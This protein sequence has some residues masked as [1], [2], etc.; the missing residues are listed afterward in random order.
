MHAQYN[1]RSIIMPRLLQVTNQ[2]P[3]T[4]DDPHQ[5]AP[6]PGKQAVLQSGMCLY[7]FIYFSCIAK[8]QLTEPQNLP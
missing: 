6:P 1:C 5:A 8:I 7:T 4:E 2:A 3:P